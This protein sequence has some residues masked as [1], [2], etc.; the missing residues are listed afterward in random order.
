[1]NEENITRM[2]LHSVTAKRLESLDFLKG[3]AVIFMMI[4]HFS[5]WF[6]DP[7][8]KT[9]GHGLMKQTQDLF[10]LIMNALGGFSAPAFVIISGMGAWFFMAGN[11]SG[12]RIIIRGVMILAAGY[13]LNL[14]C[15]VWFSLG[16]WYVLHLI[17]TMMIFVPLIRRLPHQ[18]L[19]FI[20]IAITAV[21]I[22]AQDYFNVPF[23]AFNKEMSDMSQP[24][25]VIRIALASGH[26][27]L[28]PWSGLFVLG[29]YSAPLIEKGK[30]RKV[31]SISAVS[32][33]VT[34]L[35]VLASALIDARSGMLKRLFYM[36]ESFYPMTP[37]MFFLLAGI[38]LPVA[39]LVR[40]YELRRSIS[41]LNPVVLFGRMSLTAFIA[42]V[43][44]FKQVLSLTSYYRKIPFWAAYVLAYTVIALFIYAAVRWNR[45][46][47]R[48]SLEWLVRRA[49][50]LL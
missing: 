29:Y 4:Q 11:G 37:L 47:F 22:L 40:R 23:H 15:P 43:F 30:Y 14:I 45:T 5:I 7:V 42:H 6:V 24:G 35:I 12:S 49:D 34:V 39:A 2:E 3:I 8:W 10:F 27:P 18:C 13:I 48:Y 31:Y 38:V 46:G 41:S 26:F 50:K 20:V 16:S 28:L 32:L 21:A 19:P 44:I 33:A 25:G 36:P 17:G 1:M 9:N